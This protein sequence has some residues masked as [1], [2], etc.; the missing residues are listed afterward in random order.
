MEQSRLWKNILFVAA[1]LLVSAAASLSQAEMYVAG[2][3]GLNVPRNA[4]QVDLKVDQNV[5]FPTSLNDLDLQNSFVYGGKLGYYFDSL[6]ALG[7]ETE[8]FNTTP[9]I[10]QQSTSFATPGQPLVPVDLPG[11]RLRVT[12]WAF[13]LVARYPGERFQPYAGAGV[14][15]FFGHLSTPADSTTST[16]PGFTTQLGLRYLLTQ[17]LAAFGEWKFNHVRFDYDTQAFASAVPGSSGAQFHYNANLF[18]FG[19]SYHF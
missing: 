18:V 3:A 2:Y 8:A 1:A 10:N 15:I 17:N 14:G 16:K 11:E 5:S 13:N 7:V 19:L 12:T 9:N 4:S 6:K